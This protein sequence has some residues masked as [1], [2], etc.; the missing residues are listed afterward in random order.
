MRPAPW[1][2]FLRGLLFALWPG[3]RFPAAP[4]AAPAWQRTAERRRRTLLVLVAALSASAIAV[5]WAHAPADPGVTWW[6]YTALLALLF[7]WVGAGFVTALMGAW[8]LWRGDPWGLQLP[9]ERAPI[10]R[11][12][13]TAVIMPI[14][15]EDITTVFG[16]LRATAESVAA[17]GALA[18][19]DFYVLSDT[20]VSPRI[21]LSASSTTM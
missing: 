12:A 7:A 15:N 16:G 9:D 20:S 3:V 19:F 10:D 21:V 2:G 6:A 13:R 8:V 14:C 4:N 11:S 1:F 5:Q 18:L 17:T